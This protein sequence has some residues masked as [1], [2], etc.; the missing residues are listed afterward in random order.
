VPHFYV[1][2][3]NNEIISHPSR[4]SF[5]SFAPLRNE[6]TGRENASI[7]GHSTGTKKFKEKKDLKNHSNAGN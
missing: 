6:V 2:E 7:Q 1:V 3:N 4:I 5:A